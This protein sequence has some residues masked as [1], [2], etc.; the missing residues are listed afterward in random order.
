VRLELEAPGIL[1]AMPEMQDDAAR[2]HWIDFSIAHEDGSVVRLR[3]RGVALDGDDLVF[4]NNWSSHGGPPLGTR[5][6]Q[7]RVKAVTTDGVPRPL[8]R[9]DP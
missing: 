4:F 6:R 3:S 2:R 5:I 8:N 9:K 1:F 7:V